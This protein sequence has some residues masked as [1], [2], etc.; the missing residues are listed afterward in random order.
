MRRFNLLS[1]VVAA[2]AGTRRFL[3]KTK[4][5]IAVGCVL[6]TG[7]ISFS[8]ADAA[9]GKSAVSNHA[10]C[11][12]MPLMNK[13]FFPVLLQ[14]VDDAKKEIFIAV[15]SFK[16]GVHPN[17]RP[18]LLLEHLGRAV[19]RGVSV[20]VIL[21]NPGN[22]QDSLFSQ[23]LKTKALL[24]EKGVKVYLDSPAKTTHTKLVVV[25][26]RL[27]FIGSHNFTS[28]A[29]KYNNEISVLIDKPDLAQNVRNYMLTII[30]DAK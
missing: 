23:N 12:V 29:L 19:K 27:V 21:E 10:S 26:Q 11:S 15:F 6:L 17:S 9:D 1:M 24:E 13:D 14:T 28:S 5:L 3:L 25:D 22:H 18:D 20:K 2:D 8:G 16:A 7:A 30:E 4:V